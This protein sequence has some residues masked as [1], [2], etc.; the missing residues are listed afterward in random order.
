MLNL[1]LI[2]SRAG[3]TDL[4]D[5]YIA[6]L[7][8]A[9]A[10][11]K[12]WWG[13]PESYLAKAREVSAR[14]DRASR[15]LAASALYTPDP[16]AKERLETWVEQGGF[17]VTTGQQPGLFT[18]PL[19]TIYKALTAA[20]LAAELETLLDA[21]VIPIFWVASEDHDWEESNHTYVIG[22]DNEPVRIEVD[23][24]SGEERRP[25]HRIHPGDALPAAVQKL[26]GA[27]PE[28]DFSGAYK[29][30]LERAY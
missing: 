29:A 16:A 5:D 1:E 15:E 26:I 4:A 7:P 9:R 22:R 17:A 21:P 24:P 11:F 13:D 14:F 27:L 19:Y 12:G 3:G 23:V 25:I 18:G 8:R 6:G 28:S 10:F 20:R 2:V 30:L